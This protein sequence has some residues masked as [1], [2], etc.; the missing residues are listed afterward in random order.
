MEEVM[1]ATVSQFVVY[2]I[3][4]AQ[5]WSIPVPEWLAGL[6]WEESRAKV[7][8]PALRFAITTCL[9]L[10]L[11][12]LFEKLFLAVVCIYVKVFRRKPEKVYKWDPLTEDEE[13]GNA[14]YPMVLVQIPMYNEKEVYHL[15]IG[16]VCRLSWP[17][18]RFIVQVLDDSTDVN[19]KDLVMAEC[20]KWAKKGVEINYETRSNRNGYKA[21]SLREGMGKSYV[22]GC[23]YVATFDAD[24]QPEPD[25][26]VRT[27]PFLMCNPSIALV[28]SRWKFV[29]AKECLLTRMQEIS[30]NY[31]F[32]V[33]QEAGS[34]AFAFIGYNG[35]AGVW[36]VSAINDAGGWS[37]RTTVEDMD[38][39]VR[40]S[41]KG[42]K[43][44]YVGD[45]KKISLVKKLYLIHHF[46][47]MGKIV[48][49]ALTF[50]YFC[51][52]IPISVLVPE[53]HIPAWALIYAPVF[54]T[55][56]KAVETPR[57]LHLAV[58]WV[59]FENVMSLHRVKGV[60][61]G[62]LG[63]KRVNEWVVTAK[64]GDAHKTKLL[65]DVV[66]ERARTCLVPRR[67]YPLI[68]RV[69][70]RIHM[71]EIGVGVVLVGCG[72]YDVLVAKKWYFY[73]VFLQGLA[74]LVTGFGFVGI[75]APTC[76]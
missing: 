48:A 62:L 54:I 3:A 37:D 74:F 8:A 43:F 27:I 9:V 2:T 30:L 75:H 60:M 59:L 46:F 26:L 38:L 45:V 39:A 76:D 69:W 66:N 36:R 4:R 18:N 15:S 52:L 23:E 35:T 47:F 7:I 31:H 50:S 42:W 16:A 6:T 68:R 40:A 29:N 11:M 67:R 56:C 33:E 63:A 71:K 41:L 53:V 73:Y 20:E 49:H 57:S 19:T 70:Q 1:T 14:A 13:L 21:G 64:L 17:R 24:F 61:T 32:K 12:Q 65:Q 34:S 10:L 28:Q 44:V 51:V 55:I 72:L 5:K 58:L 22:Q 25:F